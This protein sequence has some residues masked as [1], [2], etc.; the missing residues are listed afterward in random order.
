MSALGDGSSAQKPL[1]QRYC[2][3]QVSNNNWNGSVDRA[4][5]TAKIDRLRCHHRVMLTP[6]GRVSRQRFAESRKRRKRRKQ[7]ELLPALA[8]AVIRKIK[9]SPI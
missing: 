6:I 3:R 2:H 9:W 7:R 5:G 8:A 4:D 1:C